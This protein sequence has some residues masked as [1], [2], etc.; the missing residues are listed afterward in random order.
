MSLFPITTKHVKPWKVFVKNEKEEKWVRVRG[1]YLQYKVRAVVNFD[2]TSRDKRVA[3][4]IAKNLA[5]AKLNMAQPWT[6]PGRTLVAGSIITKKPYPNSPS[7]KA[8]TRG[9][10]GENS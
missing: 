5:V 9:L 6:K 2:G 8:L 1:S 7:S 3:I 4:K 10:S